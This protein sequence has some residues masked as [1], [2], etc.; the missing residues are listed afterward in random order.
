MTTDLGYADVIPPTQ[1]VRLE[2]R[3]R[4]GVYLTVD[5]LAELTGLS[6]LQV[7]SA[8]YV[9]SKQGN[10]LRR[11][12]ADTAIRNSAQAYAWDYRGMN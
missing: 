7:R 9:L 2:L 4:P 5:D 3:A 11:V 10:V 8:V 6:V 12:P 1:Q